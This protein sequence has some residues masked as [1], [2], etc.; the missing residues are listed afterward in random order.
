[1]TREEWNDWHDDLMRKLP[2]VGSYITQLPAATRDE[3][4]NNTF[5]L[6]ALSDALTMNYRIFNE[7]LLS[8]WDRDQLH[9]VFRRQL[10][11]ISSK[12]ERIEQS[13]HRNASSG[14]W[15]HVTGSWSADF[16][17]I[18]AIRRQYREE[19]NGEDIPDWKFRV[20]C[21]QYWESLE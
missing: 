11:D 19:N 1:M 13:K 4:F 17:A 9:S 21:D 2:D 15:K 8:R 10:L 6:F 7:G 20:R 3:W 14:A 12:R 5:S 16:D 18:V